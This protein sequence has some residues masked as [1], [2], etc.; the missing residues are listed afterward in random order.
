MRRCSRATCP[1]PTTDNSRTATPT[2]VNTAKSWLVYTHT[3]AA[4]SSSNIGQ[5]LVRGQI[6]NAT[7]LTFDRGDNGQSMNLTW[8]LIE[9]TDKTSVQAGSEHFTTDENY[10]NV[11]ITSVNTAKS[12]AVGGAS[13][14]EG[15]ADYSGDSPGVGWMTHELMSATN[16][17]I[18]RA[19]DGN[20]TSRHGMVRRHDSQRRHRDPCLRADDDRGGRH[21]DVHRKT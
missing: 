10:D 1:S 21:G 3:S 16:L 19:L 4:G 11:T 9:F 8:Y 12:F 2:S 13:M 7:T 17:R 6:T 20:A 18:T 14:Q 15:R 5:K